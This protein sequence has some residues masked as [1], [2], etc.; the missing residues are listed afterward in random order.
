VKSSGEVGWVQGWRE[1]DWEVL[2]VKEAKG[3]RKVDWVDWGREVDSEVVRVR[4]EEEEDSGK[5]G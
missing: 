1:A 4:E 5:V 2:R 3:L